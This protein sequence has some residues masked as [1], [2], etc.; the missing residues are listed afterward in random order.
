M[1]KKPSPALIEHFAGLEDPRIERQKRQKLLDILVLAVCAV[2]CGAESFAALEDFG[3]ARSQWLQQFLELPRGLPSH[4]PFHRV[5][6][7]LDPVQFQACFLQWRQAVAAATPGEVVAVDGKTLRHSFDTATA[8][9]AI[10]MVSAW[11][12]ENG[13]GLGQRQVDDKAN[14]LTAI[15]ALL[16]V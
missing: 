4:D 8:Q 7:L 12:T 16:E 6:G 9:R 2:L 15:P 10:P 1:E 3:Q 14:E 5:F 13:G 11:A